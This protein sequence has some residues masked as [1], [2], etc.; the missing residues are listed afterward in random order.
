MQRGVASVTNGYFEETIKKN[1]AH[2]S[3]AQLK[4]DTTAEHRY[5]GVADTDDYMRWAEKTEK[6]EQRDCLLKGLATCQDGDDLE[7][8]LES[9]E[10]TM[11]KCEILEDK[12]II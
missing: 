6:K 1:Q 11:A 7:L 10:S 8:Y 2:V 9:F 12:Y 3:R 4:R 5:G